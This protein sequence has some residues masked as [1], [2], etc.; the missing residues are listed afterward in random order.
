RPGV[1]LGER[2]GATAAQECSPV[3]DMRGSA[4]YKRHVAGVLTTRAL[5][6][7]AARALGANGHDRHSPE[8]P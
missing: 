2:A 4:E 1:G 5:R 7:A 3:S 8:A 6:R